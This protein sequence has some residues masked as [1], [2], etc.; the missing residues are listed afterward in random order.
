MNKICAQCDNFATHMLV[1]KTSSGNECFDYGCNRHFMDITDDVINAGNIF[2]RADCLTSPSKPGIKSPSKPAIKPPSKPAIKPPSKPNIAPSSTSTSDVADILATDVK[3]N[4]SSTGLLRAMIDEASATE[5]GFSV[6]PP[7]FAIGTKVNELGVENFAASRLEFE[8]KP[9]VST[10]C[11]KLI[12]QIQSE[13]RREAVVSTNELVILPN[14]LLTRK[15]SGSSVYKGGYHMSPKSFQQIMG[16]T[17]ASGGVSYLESCPAVLRAHNANY[18]LSAVNSTK[19]SKLRTRTVFNNQVHQKE[20]FAVTTP[21]YTSFDA[22][23]LGELVAKFV[24]GDAKCDIVYDGIK[25]RFTVLFHSDINPADAVAGEIFKAGIVIKTDDSGSGSIRVQSMVFRNLCLNLIVIDK[26]VQ[27]IVR[28]KHIGDYSQIEAIISEGITRAYSTVAI[29]A[30]RWGIA[31]KE[32]IMA[33]TFDLEHNDTNSV[34][35]GLSTELAMAGLM[36]GLVERELVPISRSRKD[37]I[38]G[39]MD[40]WQEEPAMTRTGVVNAISRFAHEGKHK[41]PWVEDDYQESAGN[42]LFSTKPLPWLQV[43]V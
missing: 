41:N 31:N 16:H 22:D 32:S 26:A 24:P 43:E 6:A 13:D 14:G 12:A 17:N 27:N 19:E 34:R 15:Q 30:D 28:R 37:T 9:D 18:W 4:I 38:S 35:H 33:S 3:N 36:N 7:L 25:T 40:A 10:A 39:L 11:S 23:K 29:F 1:T 2:V 8:A 20:V 21:S 42:I 5:S